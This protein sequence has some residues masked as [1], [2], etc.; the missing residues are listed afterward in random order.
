MITAS[1]PAA[2]PAA[3]ALGSPPRQLSP[4]LRAWAV[5]EFMP[6]FRWGLFLFIGLGQL[7]GPGIMLSVFFFGNALPSRSRAANAQALAQIDRLER[8]SSNLPPQARQNL[9][10]ARQRLAGRVAKGQPTWLLWGG[11]GWLAFSTLFFG[12]ILAFTRSR[13]AARGRK[14]VALLETGR[15]AAAQVA[16]NAVDYSLQVNGAPRRILDLVIEGQPVRLKTFDN[17]YA[18]LF[19]QGTSVEVLFDP[20]VPELVFPSSRLPVS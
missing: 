14:L 18:N 20:S 3:Q 2:T 13:G 19:Q 10:D 8:T 1:D 16:G 11:C 12:G 17:N 4:E 15:F 7:I 9:E 6:R 5:A